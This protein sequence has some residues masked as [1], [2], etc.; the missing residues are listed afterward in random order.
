MEYLNKLHIIPILISIFIA[1]FCGSLGARLAGRKNGCIGSIILGFI[2]SYLGQYLA[3][4]LQKAGM[5]SGV[6]LPLSFEIY[7]QKI[8]LLWNIIGATVFVALLNLVLGPQK[9]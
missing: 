2:G 5:L 4:E 1:F 6:S 8:H 9:K 3:V 7:G